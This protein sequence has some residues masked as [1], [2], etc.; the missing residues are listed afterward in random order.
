MN[1]DEF[2]EEAALY[3]TPALASIMPDL[4]QVADNADGTVCSRSGYTFPPFLVLER[5]TTLRKWMEEERNYFE[6]A[7]MVEALAR[8]LGSLHAAG[9]VH[10]D[11][12]PDNV[13]LIQSSKWRMLDLGICEIIGVSSRHNGIRSHIAIHDQIVSASTRARKAI[14]IFLLNNAA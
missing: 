2:E 8:L 1:R 3:R 10:R 14:I 9:Y 11:V 4:L 12:K 7:G 13:L 5:G 6:V